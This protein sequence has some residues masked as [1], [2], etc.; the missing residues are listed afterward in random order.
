MKCSSVLLIA[1]HICKK[2]EKGQKLSIDQTPLSAEKLKFR[3]LFALYMNKSVFEFCPTTALFHHGVSKNL[4]WN[5]F[6]TQAALW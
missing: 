3:I 6:K 4:L 2:G 1:K 5:L